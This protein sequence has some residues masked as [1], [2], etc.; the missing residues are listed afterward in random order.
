MDSNNFFAMQD[1]TLKIEQT[2]EHWGK[3]SY[4]IAMWWKEMHI[5]VY[6][7]LSETSIN[8][9]HLFV[10]TLT[11]LF[12]RSC[13][14]ECADAAFLLSLLL[15]FHFPFNCVFLT[16]GG[17]FFFLPL[18]MSCTCIY[19]QHSFHICFHRFKHSLSFHYTIFTAKIENNFEN[20]VHVAL[21]WNDRKKK[22]THTSKNRNESMK[23][24][25]RLCEKNARSSARAT[26]IFWF[27]LK[28]HHIDKIAEE[29]EID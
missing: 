28:S 19:A 20:Y 15:F 8:F 25:L 24:T 9:V 10:Y 3:K 13:K 21:K 1:G 16:F 27:D 7:Y 22:H 11:R 12:V 29:N 5:P 2:A 6:L 4:V 26:K 17:L 18:S 14:L 23:L